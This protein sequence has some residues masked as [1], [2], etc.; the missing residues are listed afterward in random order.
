MASL[1]LLAQ[2]GLKCLTG[3]TTA[4]IRLADTRVRFA[5]SA[6][7]I[8]NRDTILSRDNLAEFALF[9]G[10][11]HGKATVGPW[12]DGRSGRTP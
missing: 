1:P 11:A 4:F 5:L 12:I 3:T 8:S 6:R 2:P 9:D 10:L 7:Q